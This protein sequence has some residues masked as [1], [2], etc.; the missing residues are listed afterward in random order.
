VELG[1]NWFSKDLSFNIRTCSWYGE[2]LI[3]LNVSYE[4]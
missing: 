4:W 3:N 1:S 2:V